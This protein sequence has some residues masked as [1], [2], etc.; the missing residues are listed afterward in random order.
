M[1]ARD[2]KHGRLGDG[3]GDRLQ[4]A[5]RV[6]RHLLESSG[7]TASGPAMLTPMVCPSGAALATTSVPMFPAAPL[8]FSTTIGLPSRAASRS[9]TI[10]ATESGV[11]PASKGTTTRTGPLGHSCARHV[12]KWRP[13]GAGEQQEEARGFMGCLLSGTRN[14]GCDDCL[15]AERL[16]RAHHG[17]HPVL[18]I[19][20]SGNLN[21]GHEASC[22]VRRDL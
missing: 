17:V 16:G 4:V 6:V 21:S 18:S 19:L 20:A 7:L 3:D 1:L 12:P 5:A 8:L 10:R 15:V 9:E 13:R 2:H 14:T 11:D 22:R